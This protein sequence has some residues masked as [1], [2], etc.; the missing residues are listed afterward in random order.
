MISRAK[1]SFG[2]PLTFSPASRKASIAGSL[3]TATSQV[4]EIAEALALEQLDLAAASCGSRAPC[5]RWSRSGRARTAPSSPTS[6]RSVTSMRF[7]PPVVDAVAFEHARAQPVEEAV[8]D[9]LQR[10]AAGRLDLHAERL[11]ARLRQVGG[12][13]AARRERV[14]A[15]VGDVRGLERP[16]G[17]VGDAFG[18]HQAGDRGARAERERAL[19]LLRACAEAGALEQVR[20]AR[21]IPVAGLDRAQVVG[22][23]GAGGRVGARQHAQAQQD[24]REQA[25]RSGAAEGVA[26]GGRTRDATRLGAPGRGDFPIAPR[27]GAARA[28]IAH[29]PRRPFA[30]AAQRPCAACRHRPRASACRRHRADTRRPPGAPVCKANPKASPRP[31]RSWGGNTFKGNIL[32]GNALQ[33]N[34]RQ[35]RPRIHARMIR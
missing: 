27:A 18:M 30:G 29:A 10:A 12:L 23:V 11:A 35:V 13:R 31:P 24:Q 25:A 21:G 34:N 7:G 32:Q 15:G 5:P 8:D 14:D 9:R 28:D 22:P 17:R 33:G 4:A 1:F 16:H 6:G 19:D 3:A 2:A 20:G 26:H